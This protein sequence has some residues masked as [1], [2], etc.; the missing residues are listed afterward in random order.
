MPSRLVRAEGPHCC[1]RVRHQPVYPWL[2]C[3]PLDVREEDHSLLFLGGHHPQGHVGLVSRGPAL[4]D[5]GH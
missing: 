1:F 2:L 5:S 4:G 3:Q